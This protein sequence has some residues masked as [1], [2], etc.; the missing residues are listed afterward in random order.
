MWPMG[1]GLHMSG[2]LHCEGIVLG[3]RS[4]DCRCLGPPGPEG[5]GEIESFREVSEDQVPSL[6]EDSP[7]EKQEQKGVDGV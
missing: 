3:S 4:K 6:P 5:F 2:R 1:C 7:V